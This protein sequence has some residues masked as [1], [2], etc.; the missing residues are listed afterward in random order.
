MADSTIAYT[1]FILV[2]NWPGVPVTIAD[3]PK[4]GFTGSE[5][6]AATT[7]VFP[8]GTK[9]QVYCDGSVNT[10]GFSTFIYLKVGVQETV[11][12][13][14]LAPKSVV[15]QDSATNWYEVT[16]DASSCIA[17]PTG[18]AAVALSAMDD[19]DY[20]WFWC[21]GVC[22]KQY[23]SD[24]TGNFDTDGELL[25][26]PFTAAILAGSDTIGFAPMMGVGTS[27]AQAEALFG[28]SLAVDA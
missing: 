14:V 8:L 24:L 27:T 19:G 22:P 28:Y 6:H 23:V 11:S 12:T 4:D 3:V 10:Q 18:L 7:E 21:G 16:N 5:H 15:V 13:D 17:L 1:K 25:A 20:G 9:M 26:G 2:D